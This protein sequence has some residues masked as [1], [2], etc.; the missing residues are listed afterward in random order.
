MISARGVAWAAVVAMVLV[1]P[2]ARQGRGDFILHGNEQLTVTE[3]H[4]NGT[5]WDTSHA[6]IVS[7]GSVYSLIAY[8]SSAAS[9]SGGSVVFLNACNSSAVSVSGGSV[10]FL[11]ASNSSAVSVTGGSVYRLWAY[12]SS[13]V[14]FSGGS[15]SNLVV[16]DVPP[17]GPKRVN[18][19]GGKVASLTVEFRLEGNETFSF[20]GF[21]SVADLA[22]HGVLASEGTVNSFL[23]ALRSYGTSA[24]SITGG[25]VGYL[26]AYGFSTVSISGGSVGTGGFAANDSSV[27]SVTGGS[28]PYLNAYGFSTVDISGGSVDLATWDSSTVDIS[29]GS[30]GYLGAYG[31]T[32]TFD[33]NDM[34]IGSGL[35]LD[36]DRVLGIGILS[37][38]W[39]DGTL[40]TVNIVANESTATILAPGA[41]IP[42]PATLSLLALGGLLALRRR[43]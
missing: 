12:N 17:F 35:S 10:H 8:D 23:I 24:V 34:V 25:S 9:V 7:G 33:A 26:G 21:D 16:Y 28:V 36:G 29:G 19:S 6:S 40:W 11:N 38:E 42:E 37:G 14:N 18:I 2:L 20:S 31:G 30:V 41:Q 39:L 32:V 13:A 27:V 15:A 43:R 4:D 1:G 22:P 5:L 3:S